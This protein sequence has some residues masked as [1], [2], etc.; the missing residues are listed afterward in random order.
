M[1]FQP[2]LLSPCWSA[3]VLRSKG[4][5]VAT[6]GGDKITLDEFNTM[7]AKSN[8]GKDT[9]QKATADDREK[10]LRSLCKIQTE[11]KDAYAQ[12]YQNAP[13][14]QAE[15]QEYKRNLA[16]TLLVEHEINEPAIHRMYARKLFEVRASHILLQMPQNASPAE[17]LKT[18]L[19]AM[20]NYR[21]A[22]SRAI[23]RRT[24]SEQFPRS[25]R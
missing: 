20:I 12:G 10:I 23:L 4:T 16:V 6:I 9:A 7:F 18:Y 2:D 24:C 15:L 13:D 3:A 11:S 19:E 1:S 17:T 21:L 5:V 22:E 14:I 8:G 25:V